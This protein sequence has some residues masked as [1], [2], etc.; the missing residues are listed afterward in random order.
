MHI[1][2]VYYTLYNVKIVDVDLQL[3]QHR[4]LFFFCFASQIVF[5]FFCVRIK[6]RDRHRDRILDCLRLYQLSSSS[7]Y[8]LRVT[9]LSGSISGSISSGGIGD[10]DGDKD[11]G[12]RFMRFCNSSNSSSSRASFAGK[13]SLGIVPRILLTRT[14]VDIWFIFFAIDFKW[15]VF[16]FF[17]FSRDWD[18]QMLRHKNKTQ[19]KFRKS[20]ILSKK[21]KSYLQQL[22]IE[23]EKIVCIL[24]MGRKNRWSEGVGMVVFLWGFD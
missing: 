5:G 15:I 9:T 19:K 16:F 24:K 11:I 7:L 12:V 18:D 10:G 22:L 1:M 14:T 20:L 13:I 2:C 23:Q 4:I 3:E 6:N 21:I 8:S 17:W